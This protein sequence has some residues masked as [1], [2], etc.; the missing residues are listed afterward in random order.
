MYF[1]IKHI[2]SYDIDKGLRKTRIT[3]RYCILNVGSELTILHIIVA[4]CL[5]K[6]FKDGNMLTTNSRV[7]T[8][9]KKNINTN[10]CMPCYTLINTGIATNIS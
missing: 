5:H 2:Q 1:L 6:V 9:R 8:L 10:S 4:S 7:S 3:L